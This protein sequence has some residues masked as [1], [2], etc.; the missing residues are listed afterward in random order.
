[1]EL[2]DEPAPENPSEGE[3]ADILKKEGERINKATAGFQNVIVLAIEGKR[4]TSEQFAADIESCMASGN[5]DICFVIGG[6]FG[7]DEKIKAGS[8]LLSMS[9]MTMPHRIA[10]IVL[11]EQIFRAFKIINHETYHK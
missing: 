1:M 6:S 4:R 3:V 5:P 8:K 9:D 7:V 11:L 10:R 2:A